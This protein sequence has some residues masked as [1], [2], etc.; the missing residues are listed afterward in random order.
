MKVGDLV[1]WYSEYSSCKPT[2]DY[3][4]VIELEVNEFLAESRGAF[5]VWFSNDGNGWFDIRHP[6]IGVISESR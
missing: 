6:S 2:V 5:I 1:E 4:L 3:G